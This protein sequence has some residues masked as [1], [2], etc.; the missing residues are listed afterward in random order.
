MKN[1]CELIYKYY[2]LT[3]INVSELSWKDNNTFPDEAI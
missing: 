3:W 1:N 2:L